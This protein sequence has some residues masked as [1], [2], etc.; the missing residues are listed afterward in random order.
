MMCDNTTASE[1]VTSEANLTQLAHDEM[2]RVVG[3]A[4]CTCLAMKAGKDI[5]CE[6]PCDPTV[7][8]GNS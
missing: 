7:D 1:V 4:V 6:K 3:G 2:S 8:R 5:Y